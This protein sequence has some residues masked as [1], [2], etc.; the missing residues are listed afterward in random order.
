M[1]GSIQDKLLR[2]RPPR[3]RIT[4]DVETGGAI[5]KKELP[6]IV[7]IFADLSGDLDPEQPAPPPLKDRKMVEIDRDNFDELMRKIQPRVSIGKVKNVLPDAASETL[8]G[9]ITFANLDEFSPVKVIDKVE[10]LKV[11]YESRK[12]IRKLQAKGESSDALQMFYDQATTDPDL[13][14]ALKGAYDG[15]KIEEVD[16]IAVPDK[17][18][19]LVK[20]YYVDKDGN[21]DEVRQT[22]IGQIVGEYYL[23]VIT[24]LPAGYTRGGAAL[25]DELVAG[26]DAHL[27]TQLA[28]V[29]HAE[30]FQR[31]EATW[32]GLGY[33]VSRSETG[34]MLK[35]RV[36]DASEDDLDKDLMK[37]VEFDQSGL[38]KM[39]YEA[40]YG[41][42]G[43]APY[44][45]L[46]GDYY[47]GRTPRDIQRLE[48]LAEIAAAAHA[49]FI[50]AADAKL[51]D[52]NGFGDLAKPRDLQKIFETDEMIA[53]RA[54]R[55]SED[56]RYVS[57]TLPR[58]LMRLPYGTE[59]KDPKIANG[60]AR[61][62]PVPCEGLVYEELQSPLPSEDG[63]AFLWGNPAYVL[64]ERITHAFSLY[65]WTAAIRGVEGGGLVE[66]LPVYTY[67]SDEGDVSMICPT[68]VSI[69]D[70]REKELNDLG[71]MAIC[72][73]KK[74]NKAA[75]FGG[76]TTNK[77]KVYIS[78]L[79][80]SNAQISSMLPYILAASRFAHYLKVIMREKLGSFLTRANVE[81]YLNNWIS[82]YVLLDDNAAQGMKASYPLRA[83]KVVV[84]DV[85]GKPGAYKATMFLKPH[86]QLEEL[87]TSIRLVA[88]LP[89]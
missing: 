14:E 77:P 36:L 2:V 9:A 80:T 79:A 41:T 60:K 61:R 15:K 31:I 71:F 27:S 63:K 49:P 25:M 74:S 76:Q 64:A 81:E 68:Q 43:G 69:T 54:F 56:S 37:A 78:D 32:R 87:T 72:H 51:F 46:V 18:T 66:G 35:L 73:A 3:V 70:R 30:N 12:R 10:P 75:F 17:V 29:M 67:T 4:Y 7:G 82:Q 44:S 26:L 21:V 40:E 89:G 28:E 57:L 86:F 20:G 33:L 16:G 88:E 65:G 22:G 53:W 59:M 6:F 23:E 8:S 83:A 42:F 34:P 45:L 84:T 47:F 5:E 55:E 58:V 1:L 39:I 38:F 19:E 85:P 62:V 11:I 24:R 48:K 50:A 13:Q 52:L